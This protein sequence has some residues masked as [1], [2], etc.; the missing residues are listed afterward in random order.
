MNHVFVAQVKNLNT[1]TVLY[2][3]KLLKKSF[4]VESTLSGLFLNLEY[5]SATYGALALFKKVSFIDFY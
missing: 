3:F 1:V 4:Q 5:S 2:N